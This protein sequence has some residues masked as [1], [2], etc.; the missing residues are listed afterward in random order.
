MSEMATVRDLLRRYVAAA[1]KRDEHLKEGDD[2][3]RELCSA[4]NERERRR[5]VTFVHDIRTRQAR[6]APGYVICQGGA[7]DVCRIAVALRRTPAALNT[8]QVAR[9]GPTMPDRRTP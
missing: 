1:A 5:A 3:R 6:H 2:I 8:V 4:R 7:S 9:V